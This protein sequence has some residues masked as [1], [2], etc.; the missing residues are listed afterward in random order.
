MGLRLEVVVDLAWRDSDQGVL[1]A[2]IRLDCF[3]RLPDVVKTVSGYTSGEMGMQLW[4]PNQQDDLRGT[5]R[6]KACLRVFRTSSLGSAL[7]NARS[8][9]IAEYIETEQPVVI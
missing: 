7:A 3:P 2:E 6:S 1:E 9:D 5:Y 4:S 8:I